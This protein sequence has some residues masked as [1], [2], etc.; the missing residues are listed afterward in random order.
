MERTGPLLVFWSCGHPAVLGDDLT[1]YFKADLYRMDVFY[2]DPGLGYYHGGSRA[3]ILYRIHRYR[4]DHEITGKESPGPEVGPVR[5]FLL[6]QA[7][8]V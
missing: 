1:I 6:D 2:P 4:P 5:R 8:P 3:G 7:S